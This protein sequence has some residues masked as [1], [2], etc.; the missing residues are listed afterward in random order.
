M[1]KEREASIEA[2]GQLMPSHW[3]F[4]PSCILLVQLFFCRGSVPLPHPLPPPC[5]KKAV[6]RPLY[7]LG[8]ASAGMEVGLAELSWGHLSP[9]LPAP[10]PLPSP[11]YPHLAWRWPLMKLYLLCIVG[12]SVWDPS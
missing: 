8:L 12:A 1:G 4:C 2:Q 11:Q 7:Q 9:L 5:R 6:P 3:G 10:L